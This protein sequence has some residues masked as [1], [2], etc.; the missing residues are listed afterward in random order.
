M[1]PVKAA[2]SSSNST[3][4][5]VLTILPNDYHLLPKSQH[6]LLTQRAFET[7]L[8]VSKKSKNENNKITTASLTDTFVKNALT[9]STTKGSYQMGEELGLKK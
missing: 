2:A 4:Q 5:A 7:F 8:T 3:L 6:I 1:S 9:P